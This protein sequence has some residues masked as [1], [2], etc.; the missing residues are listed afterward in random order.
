MILFIERIEPLMIP[1]LIKHNLEYSEQ[2]GEYR[3]DDGVRGE[4]IF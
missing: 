2:V 3:Q 4:M 1:Y